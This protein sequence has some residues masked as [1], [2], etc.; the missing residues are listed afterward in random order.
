MNNL[1]STD[2]D[3]N[4]EWLILLYVAGTVIRW[5]AFSLAPSI[6]LSGGISSIAYNMAFLHL[7]SL[8]CGLWLCKYAKKYKFIWLC[9]G[10]SSDLLGV[11]VFIVV[12]YIN[13]VGSKVPFVTSEN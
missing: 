2:L 9:F 5:V 13:S 8:A 4:V 12:N 10:V 6:G 11:V 7:A 3:L 1:K